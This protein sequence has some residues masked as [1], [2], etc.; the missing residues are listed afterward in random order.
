MAWLSSI[1]TKVLFIVLSALLVLGIVAISTTLG[2]NQN[3]SQYDRVIERTLMAQSTALRANLEFKRQVQEWKNTLIRGADADQM[4]KY[5]GQFNDRH[6]SVQQWVNELLPLLETWPELQSIA[7]Q[8]LNDHRTM[9][10]AYSA[11]RNDYIAAGFDIAV[12]DRA[13]SGIDRAP[14]AAL[15]QL[16]DELAVLSEAQTTQVEQSA[17]NRV[18]MSF[19]LTGVVVAVVALISSL[20]VQRWLVTPLLRV[21]HSLAL[22]STG[23]LNEPCDYQSTDEVGDIAESSRVLEAFLKENVETMKTTSDKLS[24]ASGH[25][26]TMSDQLSTQAHEQMA[27]TDQVSTAVQEMSHS[28]EEVARNSQ[29]TSEITRTTTEKTLASAKTAAS[30]KHSAKELVSDLTTSAEDIRKL[31]ENTANVSGVLDVIRGIAEQ[32]NL[33]ALNAAIEAARAGEQGRGFAVVA[34][35]VR[36]L[37]QRTQESTAEIETILEKVRNSSEK[38]VESIDNG[39]SRSQGVENEIADASEMLDEIAALIEEINEKNLQ[40]AS[41]ST[42][43]TQVTNNISELTEDIHT[44]SEATSGQIDQARSV[45]A[46]L[47][48]L[49]SQFNSQISRFTL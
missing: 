6:E 48:D 7:E 39:Q 47:S 17:Q 44:T 5:W 40:I 3:I 9:Q 10:T 13:V 49:V 22:L 28:A 30:A 1:K 24:E 2:L 42:E 25:M 43:Q 15:D 46:E 41:A 14:S 36:T 27:A 26:A 33:L 31:A 38:A 37:A 16:V 8:F 4:D 12:G 45:S 32:T 11:G 18:R 29:D 35:E 21:R 19:V 23:K 34:D 20:L